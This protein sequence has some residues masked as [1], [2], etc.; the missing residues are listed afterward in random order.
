MP[1]PIV[2]T[3]KRTM[4]NGATETYRMW[5]ASWIDDEGVRRVVSLGNAE[6]VSERDAKAKLAAKM[7]AKAKPSAESVTVEWWAGECLAAWRIDK[8][9][10]TVSDYVRSHAMLVDKWGPRPLRSITD[11][12]AKKWMNAIEGSPYTKRR[13]VLIA[14]AWFNE[15]TRMPRKQKPYLLSSP[16]A[17]LAI[18]SPGETGDVRYI[19]VAERRA[20]LEALPDSNWRALVALAGLCGMRN[21]EA[22]HVRPEHLNHDSR[23]IVVRLREE[24]RGKGGGTKQ[25]TRLVPMSPA[26]YALIRER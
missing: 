11:A 15:A 7:Q 3:Q 18:P 21:E 2:V 1:Q 9:Q 13:Y 6:K 14:A 23:A 8:A 12:D 5:R 26:A 24:R 17:D 10:K 16:F 20:L 19:T 22:F 4:V 25:G